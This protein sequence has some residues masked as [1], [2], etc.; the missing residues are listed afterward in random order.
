MKRGKRA[1]RLLDFYVGIPVLSLFASLRRRGEQSESP[2]RI[3]M[4][5]NPALGDTL[6]A[7]AA[8]QDIRAIYPKSRLILFAT[9]A[10][11][12]AARLLPE[13]D[14]IELLPITR[15]LQCI[16]QLKE[17][18][19]D[20]MLDFTAWQRITAFY[21]LMS[22]AKFTVGFKRKRQYRHQ[23]YDK[24]V[25]HRGD[26]HELENLRRLTGALG[27]ETHAA[28]RLVIPD[29]PLP[30][31]VSQEGEVVVFHPWA[32]GA[33]S[34][35]R[36]WPDER[37]AE[38]ARQL[39]ESGRS[40]LLTGSVADEARCVALSDRLRRDGTPVQILIGRKGIAEVATV[41]QHAR[42]LISVNTGIMHLGAILGTPTISINGPTSAKR[43]GPVGPKVR[44]VSPSDGSG[45]FLDLGF[46]Y[47][48]RNADVMSKITVP[49]VMLA[50]RELEATRT[51]SALSVGIGAPIA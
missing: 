22:G 43:W 27:V 16:R 48:G 6:L 8:T 32:S 41:L 15:P 12:A 49:E 34:W 31:V 23:G 1:N 17:A 29:M 51:I 18:D 47:R 9:S 2:A 25:A 45:E 42:M 13:V 11:A 38:L 50:V 20:V 19:L 28:P 46:E 14:S 21:T 4:L 39:S 5:F 10:N 7:S 36:E 35:L 3:G 44:N 30:D 26:C 40:F 37:W 24:T 33:R